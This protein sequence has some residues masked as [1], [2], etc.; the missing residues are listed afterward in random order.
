[1]AL[2][3]GWV[4]GA[5]LDD[6]VADAR[7]APYGRSAPTPPE[8]EA[9]KLLQAVAC[10]DL[11]SLRTDDSTRS[12]LSLCRTARSP[13]ESISLPDLEAE[14]VASVAAVCVYPSCVATAVEALSG[15]GVH[16]A[17]A[18]AFPAGDGPLQRQIGEIE[19]AR[20]SGAREV[21]VVADRSFA[22][23][24]DWGGLYER[25]KVFREAADSIV[26]KVILRSGTLPSASHILRAS[27]VCAMAGADFIKTSTGADTPNATFPAGIAIADAIREYQSQTG[28]RVGLKPAGSLRTPEQALGWLDLARVELGAAWTV[29]RLFRI[30]ASSLLEALRERLAFLTTADQEGPAGDQ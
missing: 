25:V 4:R 2:D 3:L 15:T 24:E 9:G 20:T 14:P 23:N 16:V 30:G 26:L 6:R 21:D 12:V 8:V 17:A 13:L 18:C 5:R 7:A 11:T 22:V 10:L 29:P 27:L 28:S 1:M 19:A